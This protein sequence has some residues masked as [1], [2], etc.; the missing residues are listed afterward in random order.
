MPS[1]K[2]KKI[3]GNMGPCGENLKLDEIDFLTTRQWLYRR[4]PKSQRWML[5]LYDLAFFQVLL[6]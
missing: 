4:V 6:P 2:I 5:L 3:H 1:R